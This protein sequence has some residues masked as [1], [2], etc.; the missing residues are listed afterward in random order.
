M[1]P[2]PWGGYLALEDVIVIHI[3]LHTFCQVSNHY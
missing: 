2:V 1:T 3:L